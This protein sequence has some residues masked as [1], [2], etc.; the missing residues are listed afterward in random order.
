MILHDYFRST[1]AYR[2]RI[3][4]NLKGIAW[5]SAVINLL[6][7][8]DHSEAYR[9]LNPQ[10]LVPALSHDN[11]VLSQSLAICEYLEEIH[12]EPGL[13]PGTA[14]DRAKIRA[15]AQAI[16]CDI[17]PLNNL[18]VLKYLQ[19]ALSVSDDDK[20]TWYHH[21]IHETFQALEKQLGESSDGRFCFGEQATLA[22]ICLIPQ[23]YNA[24][25]FECDLSNYPVIRSIN[26]HC[27]AQPAFDSASPE[28][29]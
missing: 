21:W 24:N 11:N 23:V 2:V 28:K 8:E 1:A 16:A 4:L 12:P 14:L 3:A 6:E 13:L 5:N 18:R 9:Q 22:D 15:F 26:A 19:G 7:G 20:T 10:V 29:R 27:L 25:R 17:H